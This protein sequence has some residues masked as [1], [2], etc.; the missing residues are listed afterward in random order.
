MEAPAVRR[1]E[2]LMALADAGY[3]ELSRMRV[4]V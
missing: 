1:A 2:C 4:G 3:A